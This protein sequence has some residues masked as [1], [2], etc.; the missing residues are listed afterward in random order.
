MHHLGCMKPCEK[1]DKLPTS[2]GESPDFWTI[3]SMYLD[4]FGNYQQPRFPNDPGN[5]S[6][7]PEKPC[8]SFVPRWRSEIWHKFGIEATQQDGPFDG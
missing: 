6:Q 1:W 5:V 3:N 4:F 2:T 7:A 8:R